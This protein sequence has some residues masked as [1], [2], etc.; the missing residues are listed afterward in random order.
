MGDNVFR[1]Y[2]GCGIPCRQHYGDRIPPF[3]GLPEH[4]PARDGHS[5]IPKGEGGP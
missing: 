5:G 4:R 2:G 3:G 1:L